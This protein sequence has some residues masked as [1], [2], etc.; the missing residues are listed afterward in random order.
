MSTAKDVV[1][2]LNAVFA[3]RKSYRWLRILSP[4]CYEWY[5]KGM[6]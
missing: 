6:A 5:V 1:S 4:E 2:S 3:K